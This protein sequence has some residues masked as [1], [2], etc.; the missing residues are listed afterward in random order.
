MKKLFLVL[1]FSLM[2][3]SFAFAGVKEAYELKKQGKTQEAI[4]EMEITLKNNSAEKTASNLT[5]LGIWYEI[6]GNKEKAK[7]LFQEAIAIDQ[8][9]DFA[10]YRLGL[11]LYDEKNYEEAIKNFQ[12]VLE[13]NKNKDLV[14][15]SNWYLG[16]CYRKLKQEDKAQE[17]FI[18]CCLV[19]GGNEKYMIKSLNEI[20]FTTMTLEKKDELLLK[21]YNTQNDKKN[22]LDFLSTVVSNMSPEAQS[23][24][25]KGK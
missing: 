25:T 16:L 3:I 7:E 22:Y 21:M 11:R 14:S 24:V 17:C 4:T 23:K 13:I 9:C 8:Q 15:F 2:M 20:D 10:Y 19:K 5:E 18:N 6:T 12:K 1:V